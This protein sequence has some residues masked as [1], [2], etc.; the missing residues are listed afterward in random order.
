[1]G[2]GFFFFPLTLSCGDM[3]LAAELERMRMVLSRAQDY[4]KTEMRLF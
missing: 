1:M 2:L 3:E 4:F